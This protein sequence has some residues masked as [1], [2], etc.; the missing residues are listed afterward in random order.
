MAFARST[1]SIIK[2][3]LLFIE[4][5]DSS[6]SF[7]RNLKGSLWL[8]HLFNETMRP[9]SL[10]IPSQKE[11]CLSNWSLDYAQLRLRDDTFGR[12]GKKKK[13]G[14]KERKKRKETRCHDFANLLEGKTAVSLISPIPFITRFKNSRELHRYY[15]YRPFHFLTVPR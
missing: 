4:L 6:A 2:G 9:V 12:R 14:K 3:P 5:L 1:I 7:P 10:Q 8:S 15:Y 13:E 11:S